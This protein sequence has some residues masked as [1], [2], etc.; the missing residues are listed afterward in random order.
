MYI[1]TLSTYRRE[2]KNCMLY[3]RK[4]RFFIYI[5][6]LLVAVL[7][8]LLLLLL[9]SFRNI[10]RT[11]ATSK[12][13]YFVTLVNCWKLFNDVTKNSILDAASVLNTFPDDNSNNNKNNNNNK[14]R[15]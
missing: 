14:T 7:S 10:S 9:S 12:M 2:T 1:Y 6:V 15:A 5:L 13:E 11:P 8:L 3:E 4:R